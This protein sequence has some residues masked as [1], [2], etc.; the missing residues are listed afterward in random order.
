M[1]LQTGAAAGPAAKPAP[2]PDVRPTLFRILFAISLVHLFND[3]IQSVIPA[4]LPIIKDSMQLSYMQ[5]GIIVFALNMTASVMQPVVGLYSDR[6]PMPYMLPLGMGL[7]F[8]GVLGLALAPNYALV[9]VSVLLIGLGSAVFHPE[10]SRV[11]YMAG[12]SRRGLAQS[13][14]QVGGNTGQSLAS[15]MTAL[16]FVPLGQFGAIWFTAVAGLAIVVQMYISR[17]YAG[18]L[19]AHPRPAK[20]AAARRIDPLRSRQIKFA[21]GMLIFLVFAR[22]WYHAGITIYYPFYLMDKFTITLERAQ[23]FIFLFTAAGVLSTFLGGPISDKIGRRN[24]IF[25]SM[26]GSAPLALVLPYANEFWTYVILLVNGFIILSS[27]SVTVVYAQELIPGKVGTVSGLITGLA[28]GLGA[29]GAVALGGLIDVIKLRPV[30]ELVSYL[31]L[32]GLLTFFL[33]RDRTLKEWSSES[34][35]A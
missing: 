34:G 24:V 16:V 26:L 14:F 23:L 31:P 4:I 30:M 17:W 13:I 5:A 7:T 35:N 33:P 29:L 9:L 3:T 8:F 28:F 10:G 11:A 6:K 25:F 19:K 18:Y 20:S 22:S 2:Q 15:I 12:G 21:V 32:I 27:F 1:Q